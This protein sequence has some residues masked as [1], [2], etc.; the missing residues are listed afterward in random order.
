MPFK[1]GLVSSALHFSGLSGANL[2]GRIGGA[3]DA[4]VLV[5]APQLGNC[6]LGNVLGRLIA[7]IV[8]AIML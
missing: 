6:F 4:S 5:Q 3:I 1:I 2:R 8:M 7:L